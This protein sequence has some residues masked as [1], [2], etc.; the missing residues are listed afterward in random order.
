MKIDFNQKIMNA[1]GDGPLQRVILCEKCKQ[2]YPESENDNDYTLADIASDALFIPEQGI[3]GEE[4]A[5]RGALAISI[6]RNRG[7]LDLKIEQ[8][9][10]IKKRIGE[11]KGPLI[12]AQAWQMLEGK[13]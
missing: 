3:T 9:A 8:V 10:L 1:K 6:A 11:T 12:I 5:R 4:G 7:V 13:E 2:L